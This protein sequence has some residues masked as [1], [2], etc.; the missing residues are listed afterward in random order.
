VKNGGDD[1]ERGTCERGS[2]LRARKTRSAKNPPGC[3]ARLHNR[4][5]DFQRRGGEREWDGRQRARA[6]RVP[7]LVV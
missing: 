1:D 6:R 5:G 4:F 2:D 7:L 3:P